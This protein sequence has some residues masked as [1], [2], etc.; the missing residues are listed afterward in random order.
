MM[1]ATVIAALLYAIGAFGIM[2]LEIEFGDKGDDPKLHFI[3]AAL[4]P[5]SVPLCIV[6]NQINGGSG[7]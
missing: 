6:Y 7:E 3:F 1:T 4:W 5:I 2:N